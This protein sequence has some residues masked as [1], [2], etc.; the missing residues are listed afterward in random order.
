MTRDIETGNAGDEEN[1]EGGENEAGFFY[2]EGEVPGWHDMKKVGFLEGK[3][4][5]G[6]IDEKDGGNTDQGKIDGP[7]HD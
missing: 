1:V 5:H 6:K 7:D 2:E 4:R 3:S